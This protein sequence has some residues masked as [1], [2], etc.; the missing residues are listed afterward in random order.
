MQRVKRQVI[1]WTTFNSWLPHAAR[2]IGVVHPALRQEW[3]IKRFETWKQT[4][5]Q[6]LFRQSHKDWKYVVRCHAQSKAL[7]S[8]LFSGIDKRVS[9]I[10]CPCNEVSIIK[11]LVGDA[12]EVLMVRLDSDD[13]Y[14]P[15][16]LQ[17]AIE[18][19]ESS[20]RL[21]AYW[22]RGYAYNTTNKNIWKYET[23]SSGPFFVHRWKVADLLKYG[24]LQDPLRHCKIKWQRSSELPYRRFCVNVNHGQND[25]TRPHRKRFVEMVTDLE[26]RQ[27]ISTFYGLKL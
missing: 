3:I 1:V 27:K 14:H 11:Q 24:R 2:Y 9:A 10:Y 16:A 25:S 23:K 20:D 17:Q 8:R 13:C 5:L 12:D 7:C 15:M 6:S 21:Y 18:W 22:A 4:A 26:L 19:A